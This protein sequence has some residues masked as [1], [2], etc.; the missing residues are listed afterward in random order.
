M[1]CEPVKD[2]VDVALLLARDVVDTDLAFFERLRAAWMLTQ[3]SSFKGEV[4]GA[5]KETERGDI[6]KEKKGKNGEEDGSGGGKRTRM[7]R[8]N[9]KRGGIVV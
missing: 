1:L 4:G 2:L 8:V 7:E 3:A 5:R 9:C 6:V